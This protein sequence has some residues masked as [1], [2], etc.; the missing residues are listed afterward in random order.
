MAV[1][2]IVYTQKFLF[3]PLPNLPDVVVLLLGGASAFILAY[4]FTFVVIKLCRKMGW[5]DQPEERRVHT[6]AVPRLGGVAM[7]LA[8]LVASFFFYEPGDLRKTQVI[9]GQT[10]PSE[11]VSYVL[12]LI[13]ATLIVAVHAYDDVKGLKPRTK[14]LAQTIAVII[15]L[16]PDLVTFQFHGVLLFGFSNPFGVPIK[17]PSLPWY[18]EPEISLFIH[19]PEISW[20]AIPAVL[21]TWFWMAGMMNTVNL[22]DGLDGLATG[23]VAI[24]GLF[25]TIISWELNQHSIA[26]LAGIFTGASLGFLPHNWNPAKIFMGDS[27][28]QFLG[29]GLAVLSI[30][31]GAKVALALMVLGIPILDVAVVIINR[32][33]HKQPPLHYDKSHLHYRLLATGLSVRQICYVFYGLTLT[34]GVLALGLTRIYKFIGIALVGVTMVGLVIWIDYRQRQRGTR[35]ELNNPDLSPTGGAVEPAEVTIS[36]SS[37]V[38]GEPTPPP[39]DSTGGLLRAQT[40]Q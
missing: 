12:F 22:I 16:G 20:L 27:G 32:I 3:L 37:G 4:L 25:I 36:K 33:R 31:G 24:T 38:A 13:A 23:V 8:F 29:L 9:F 6:V 40:P 30:M 18:L 5:L 19:K 39:S 10:Y 34:F 2:S 26:F 7:L 15:V 11:L 1:A 14:L 17:Q 35:I 28:S 21:L